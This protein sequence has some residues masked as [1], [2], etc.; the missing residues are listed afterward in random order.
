VSRRV[1]LGTLG[2]VFLIK[3]FIYAAEGRVITLSTLGPQF[4]CLRDP[5]QVAGWHPQSGRGAPRWFRSLSILLA[6]VSPARENPSVVGFGRARGRCRGSSQPDV[7]VARKCGLEL[8]LRATIARV[9]EEGG[10][11]A[12]CC[13][14]SSIPIKGIVRSR[15]MDL[16]DVFQTSPDTSAHEIVRVEGQHGPG[17]RLGRRQRASMVALSPAWTAW[18]I[19][20]SA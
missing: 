11:S 5:F 10:L 17:Q 8:R 4:E 2:E 16:G 15:R 7:R 6:G 3:I 18:V 13:P 20:Y 19:T 14:P 1:P 9:F 12:H